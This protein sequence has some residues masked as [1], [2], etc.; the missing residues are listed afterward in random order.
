[1]RGPIDLI[2]ILTV[3]LKL[4]YN[5]I[6]FMRGNP[7]QAIFSST[8][9]STNMIYFAGQFSERSRLNKIDAA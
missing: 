6:S 3:E 9:E 7:L 4:P 2:R 1:M 8:D 5:G